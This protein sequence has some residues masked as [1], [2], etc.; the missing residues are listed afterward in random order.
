LA[1]RRDLGIALVAGGLRLRRSRL[2]P[3]RR[4]AAHRAEPPARV[5]W[6]GGDGTVVHRVGVETRE[7]DADEQAQA[8]LVGTGV[9]AL[10]LAF[11]AFTGVP[12]V[13]LRR[14]E[15]PGSVL[16][17]A[18]G[19][20][21]SAAMT[22]AGTMRERMTVLRVRAR[23]VEQHLRTA[24]PTAA[25]RYG[26]P[27]CRLGGESISISMAAPIPPVRALPCGRAAQASRG[28]VADN[29]PRGIG[30]YIALMGVAGSLSNPGCPPRP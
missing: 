8:S 9:V 1:Q 26:M 10:L 13:W 3:G 6:R 25:P 29:L 7:R 12:V 24:C 18:E 22:S 17:G 20:P 27:R 21:R 15:R 11:Q 19:P 30:L 5:P 2:L 23:S 14:Q 28:V 16:A 4:P